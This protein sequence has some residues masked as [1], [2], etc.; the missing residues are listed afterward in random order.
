MD[1]EDFQQIE[2]RACPGSGTCSGMFT[3]NT[4]STC[5]EALGQSQMKMKIKKKN[6]KIFD[7]KKGASSRWLA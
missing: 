6:K 4:M 2:C 5:I 7:R 1:I 3:A